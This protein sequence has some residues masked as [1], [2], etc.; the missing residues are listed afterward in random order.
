MA[1]WPGWILL[2]FTLRPAL[3]TRLW[4]DGK[5]YLFREESAI[6][7]SPVSQFTLSLGGTQV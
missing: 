2:L 3:A 4:E 6:Q 7:A 1:V 5:E